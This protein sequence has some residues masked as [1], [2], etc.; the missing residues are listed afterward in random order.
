M[1]DIVDADHGKYMFVCCRHSLAKPCESETMQPAESYSLLTVV[2]ASEEL[3]YGC[4]L[5]LHSYSMDIC[6][7]QEALSVWRSLWTGFFT[8]KQAKTKAEAV[9][10]VLD[11]W[12]WTSA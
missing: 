3:L 8:T 1:F 2:Y 12:W 9:Y 7:V 6:F 10:D 4:S 5:N 11:W